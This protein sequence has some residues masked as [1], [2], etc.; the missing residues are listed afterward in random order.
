MYFGYPTVNV[1]QIVTNA[2]N[3]RTGDNPSYTVADFLTVYPQFGE[4]MDETPPIESMVEEEIKDKVASNAIINPDII[5]LY[6]DL[7]NSC[8]K[9]ARWHNSWKIAMGLF[10]AHWCI[11]WLR[12][13]STVDSGKDAVVQ[14]GQT[15]GIITTESVDGVSYSMDVSQVMQDL[16]GYGSWT[17]T[18]YGTQLATLSKLYGK[19]MTL[20]W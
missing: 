18:D 6:I 4:M 13:S 15:Q 9:K 17:T 11:L 3:I 2:S 1:N 16:S 20:V 7:A 5:Q 19:G 12:S 8:I 14:A 10:V